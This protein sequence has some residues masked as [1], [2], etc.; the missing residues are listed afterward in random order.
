MSQNVN[1]KMK[2]LASRNSFVAAASSFRRTQFLIKIIFCIR[3]FC[4]KFIMSAVNQ[5]LFFCYIFQNVHDTSNT[6]QTIM[7]YVWLSIPRLV[8]NLNPHLKW[9]FFLS[10]YSIMCHTNCPVNLNSLI[11]SLHP[12]AFLLFYYRLFTQQFFFYLN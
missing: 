3:Q 11:I 4:F 7:I 6:L 10:F 8:T 12:I 5:E 9:I 1:V 2:Y